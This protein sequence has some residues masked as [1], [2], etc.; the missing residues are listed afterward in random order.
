VA[1]RVAGLAVA[2]LV[3]ATG[4]V[5]DRPLAR[6]REFDGSFAASARIA[7]AAGDRQGVF[8]WDRGARATTLFPVPLWLQ[9]DQLSLLL[10]EPA[11]PADLAEL[12]R[13]FPGQPV[14]VVTGRDGLPPG[15]RGAGLTRAD[16]FRASMPFWEQSVSSRPDRNVG[17][18]VDVEVWSAGG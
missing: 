10:P 15:L 17:I 5:Q 12:R 1:V 14:F 3:V 9:R 8:V 2:V 18:R 13:A 16:R 7:A 11:G 6:H 4:L